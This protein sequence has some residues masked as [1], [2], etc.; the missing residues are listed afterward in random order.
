V[1]A[2]VAQSTQNI[3]VFSLPRENQNNQLFM[4]AKIYFRKPT[5][6]KPNGINKTFTQ[7]PAENL[8]PEKTIYQKQLEIII[9]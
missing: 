4:T 8:P 9:S 2:A 6:I 7:T 3:K 5:Y 1:A